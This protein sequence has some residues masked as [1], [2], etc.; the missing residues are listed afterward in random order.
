MR[1][2]FLPLFCLALLAAAPAAGGDGGP[3][4]GAVMGWDGVRVPIGS[5]RYVALPAGA[6]TTVAAIDT[7]DG[8]VLRYGSVPG[9]YGIPLVA[10]DGSS[11]ALSGDGTTLAL[12]WFPTPPGPA[13]VSR[14]ALLSAKTLRLRH[15]VTLPGSFSYDAVS[16]NGSTLYLVQYISSRDWTRY[17]VRAFDLESNRLVPGAIVDKREPD[18]QMQG[19]PLTRAATRDGGWA[20][21]LYGRDNQRAFIHALDTRHRSARCIDLPWRLDRGATTVSMTV[22]PGRI[23]LNQAGI[24][25]LFVDTRTFAVTAG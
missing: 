10:Y 5:L 24:G 13:V 3:S 11:G 16:P 15:A 1:T 25:R 4:P 22:V 17:R 7:T 2:R 19:Y 21:T 23:V 8:R 6:R 14:F 9:T 12:S 18:E 20:Y